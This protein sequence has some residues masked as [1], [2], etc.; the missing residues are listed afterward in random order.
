MAHRCAAILGI[1]LVFTAVSFG[2]S[3]KETSDVVTL[4]GQIQKADYN[5]D[6]AALRRLYDELTPVQANT[7]LASRV[8]YWGGFALWRR[9]SNGLN[10]SAAPEE[11]QQD[12]TEALGEFREGVRIDPGFLDAK[13]GAISCLSNLIFLNQKNSA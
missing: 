13:T 6:R 5:G 4:V 9:A 2:A 12:L 7:R 1:F 3:P 11:L 8:G 10:E